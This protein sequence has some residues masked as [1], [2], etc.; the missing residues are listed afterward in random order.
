MRE[1]RFSFRNIG[2]IVL[3]VLLLAFKCAELHE[4]AHKNG[5]SGKCK[6]CMLAHA[7]MHTEKFTAPTATVFEPQFF[8]KTVQLPIM[9]SVQD[10]S[11]APFSGNFLNKAPPIA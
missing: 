2:S 7:Q 3:V 10:Y 11:P 5:D 4:F 8:S 9:A 1:K 6:I